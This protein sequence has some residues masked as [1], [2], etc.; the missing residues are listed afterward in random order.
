[1]IA[2]LGSVSCYILVDV[3]FGWEGEMRYIIRNRY[4]KFTFNL[5]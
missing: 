1:L 4:V 2:M 5:Q 3:F